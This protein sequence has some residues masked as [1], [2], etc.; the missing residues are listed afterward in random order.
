MSKTQP[1]KPGETRTFQSSFFPNLVRTGT[2]SDGNCFFHSIFQCS[3]INYR[4]MKEKERITYVEEFRKKLSGISIDEWIN[5][6]PSNGLIIEEN[7]RF[8]L[9]DFENKLNTEVSNYD[10]DEEYIPTYK[11]IFEIMPTSIYFSKTSDILN[12]ELDFKNSKKLFGK[13]LADT[14]KKRIEEL[15]NEDNE[16]LEQ[17][18]KLYFYDKLKDLGYKIYGL[19]LQKSYQD[20]IEKLKNG[21]WTDQYT[22]SYISNFLKLNIL[23]I[24]A[25]TRFPYKGLGN[26][27]FDKNI[28]LLW[29]DENHFESIGILKDANVVEREFSSNHE[30]IKKFKINERV[31]L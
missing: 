13:S 12:K 10:I 3:S 21:V 8:F 26:Q 15:E 5:S 28:I 1:I 30:I 6:S 23:F 4:K 2:F 9:E 16:T 31:N 25:S 22:I 18:R 27:N 24:D 29:I 14:L 7:L 17:H 20:F 19:A 11:I